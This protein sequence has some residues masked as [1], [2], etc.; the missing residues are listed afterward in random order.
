MSTEEIL[1]G[2]APTRAWTRGRVAAFVQRH[3]LAWELVMAALTIVYVVVAFLQ[4]QGSSGPVL[5]ATQL[6]AGFFVI[7]FSLRL[8]DSPSRRV[9][10]RNHWLDI[11]TCI[12]VV[13]SFRVLR[14]VRLLAFVR[15]GANL[16]AFGLGAAASERV[17]GG[18]GLWVL[19]PVLLVVWVAAAY[20]FYTLEG[21]VNPNIKTFGD[22]L[23][24]ALVTASTVGYGDVTPVTSEGKVLTGLVIFVGI[25]LLGFGSA[26][27]TAKLLPQRNEVAELKATVDRQCQ[28]LEDLNTRLAGVTGL[29]EQQAKG[30]LSH[31][32]GHEV[33][34]LV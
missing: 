7:E 5:L 32:A 20:G 16:R 27:L 6:L 17:Y 34:Q 21:G 9:Y 14:L 4:D 15:L 3:A 1:L 18:A 10:L 23:Y 28:M 2:A 24:F 33:P 25:G 22:A 8:Y 31:E 30:A 12:P 13:G 11:V 26:Q 19:A 29:L